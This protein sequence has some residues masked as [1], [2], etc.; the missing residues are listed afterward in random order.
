MYFS[1][2]FTLYT[3]RYCC[4]CLL[5]F[6]EG[7]VEL[8]DIFFFVMLFGLRDYCICFVMSY[9]DPMDEV[10]WSWW[11][12]WWWWWCY[13]F[14]RW[15]IYIY[16]CDPTHIYIYK[17]LVPRLNVLL[18]FNGVVFFS[19][20]FNRS[21]PTVDASWVRLGSVAIWQIS[22]AKKPVPP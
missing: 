10:G 18:F 13:G 22:C 19:K 8:V 1:S 11:W 15:H 14:K 4:S 17:H 7:F 6:C 2:Y 21:S 12:W 5:I 9:R 16:I 20:F 3:S